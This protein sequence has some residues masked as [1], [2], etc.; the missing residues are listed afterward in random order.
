MKHRKF[1][2]DGQQN[3][4]WIHVQAPLWAHFRWDTFRGVPFAEMS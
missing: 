3:G 2:L 1:D 4:W